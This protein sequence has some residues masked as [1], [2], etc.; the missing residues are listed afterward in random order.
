MRK[1]Y[2]I[3][4]SI[5][6]MIILIT[7]VLASCADPNSK[8]LSLIDI[9]KTDINYQLKMSSKGEFLGEVAYIDMAIIDIQQ[10]YILVT[11][12][13]LTGALAKKIYYVGV[14][15]EVYTDIVGE[16]LTKTGGNFNTLRADTFAGI[17]LVFDGYAD[18]LVKGDKA[19]EYVVEES[20]K[21]TYYEAVVT[22]SGVSDALVYVPSLAIN[23]A[24]EIKAVK[25]TATSEGME[26]EIAINEVGS[27]VCR[28]TVGT[29]SATLPADLQAKI[30]DIAND[31]GAGDVGEV[32]DEDSILFDKAIN[33]DNLNIA[34]TNELGQNVLSVIVNDKKNMILK[35]V[36]TTLNNTYAMNIDGKRYFVINADFNKYDFYTEENADIKEFNRQLKLG[37]G[38]FEGLQEF[39]LLDHTNQGY[40]EYLI[41]PNKIDEYMDKIMELSI[42]DNKYRG[43]MDNTYSKIINAATNKDKT[44]FTGIRYSFL[45]HTIIIRNS[46]DTHRHN[47]HFDV[48]EAGT[49]PVFDHN[50]ENIILDAYN[51]RKN[52]HKYNA[53]LVGT[54]YDNIINNNVDIKT[55]NINGEYDFNQDFVANHGN[56]YN[57][58]YVTLNNTI[59]SH[60]KMS[61]QPVKINQTLFQ[62]WMELKKAILKDS[63]LDKSCMEYLVPYDF[64][65][66]GKYIIS[67]DKLSAYNHNLGDAF[68]ESILAEISFLISDDKFTICSDK[69]D[70][71]SIIFSYNYDSTADVL[72]AYVMIDV[73]E[74]V[75]KNV[76][77]IFNDISNA[78]TDGNLEIT[79][80]DI[81]LS[82][83][84]LAVK[85]DVALGSQTS[86]ATSIDGIVY[87][88]H[89]EGSKITIEDSGSLLD[90]SQF[91]QSQ[92]FNKYFIFS[93]Y[94]KYLVA[95]SYDLGILNYKVD[96]DRIAEYCNQL[97]DA[98]EVAQEKVKNIVFTIYG[99]K[100][101]I[102]SNYGSSSSSHVYICVTNNEVVIPDTVLSD[103]NDYINS[104]PPEVTFLKSISSNIT[105]GNIGL[106]K[107]TEKLNTSNNMIKY[108]SQL[109]GINKLAYA[110]GWQNSIL[111]YGNENG[112]V[113]TEKAHGRDFTKFVSSQVALESYIFDGFDTYLIPSGNQGQKTYVIDPA[114]YAEYETGLK[115]GSQNYPTPDLLAQM[116]FTIVGD[117]LEIEYTSAEGQVKK[118]IVSIP[119]ESIIV[120]DDVQAEFEK[121]KKGIVT[122]VSAD[123]I[124]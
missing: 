52:A 41:N 21:D 60:E 64:N 56:G 50:A 25:Y 105:K 96:P 100:I 14:G 93:G 110:T 117:K 75:N 102:T 61:T 15:E 45:G 124:A 23:K 80:G 79:Q 108:E 58:Y 98:T 94:D 11:T 68:D 26:T 51:T 1:R 27:L 34:I 91:K 4:A 16:T 70:D 87:S 97:G 10:G 109:D 65:S 106:I 43:V 73:E 74:F 115:I 92:L 37:G 54:Q 67:P 116:V 71:S 118:V 123:Q 72:P 78:I 36:A 88:Y 3:L 49:E 33:S 30:D 89:K 69:S 107:D 113:K 99:D 53:E 112:V 20:K 84:K 119:V 111:I 12:Y 120:P 18:Y 32:T 35:D 81:K 6:A 59:Y 24:E 5:L 121:L 31:G 40:N 42:A 62:D 47:T 103:I 77:T 48:I 55:N 101:K 29:E 63:F 44:Y 114:R 22:A 38:I 39:L 46:A 83:S 95:H 86:Y 82:I 28:T 90:F 122:P 19:S 7:G 85:N 17:G 66:T 9:S 104:K 2:G 13:D 76:D 57:N 8:D